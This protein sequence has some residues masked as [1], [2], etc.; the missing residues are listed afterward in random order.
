MTKPGLAESFVSRTCGLCSQE[1]CWILENS[2]WKWA[3]LIWT[4]F[5]KY[6][7]VNLLALYLQHIHLCIQELGSLELWWMVSCFTSSTMK[8]NRLSLLSMLCSCKYC[9]SFNYIV[10]SSFDTYCLRLFLS[11]PLKDHHLKFIFC[12]FSIFSSL[13]TTYR[14]IATMA[15]QWRTVLMLCEGEECWTGIPKDL[16]NKLNI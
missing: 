13:D 3:I 9:S 14:L 5:W 16:V 11:P 1:Q 7:F 15:I 6:S 2:F 12:N 10:D 4:R 8:G